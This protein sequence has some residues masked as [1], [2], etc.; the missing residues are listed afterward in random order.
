MRANMK[1]RITTRALRCIDKKG[2]LDNYLLTAPDYKLLS[3]VGTRLRRRLEEIYL[4][5]MGKPFD[6][7]QGKPTMEEL[8]QQLA[9]QNKAGTAQTAPPKDPALIKALKALKRK[10]KKEKEL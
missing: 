6:P 10:K 2:G 5:T 1:L 4:V 9:E 7:R 8:Y 3:V